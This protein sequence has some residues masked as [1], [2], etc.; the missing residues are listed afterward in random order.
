MTDGGGANKDQSMPVHGNH[1]VALDNPGGFAAYPAQAYLPNP[2]GGGRG[3]WVW[4]EQRP[5]YLGEDFFFTGNHPE[6][7][8]IGGE[9]KIS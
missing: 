1:Y 7:S 3:R 5:R 8:T 6:L 9:S 2:K 4:D